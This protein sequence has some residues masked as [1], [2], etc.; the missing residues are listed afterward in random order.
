MKRKP[1]QMSRKLRDTPPKLRVRGGYG[2]WLMDLK[3][4]IR[5][6]Q[7]RAALAVNR[8]LIQLYWDIGRDIVMKQEKERWGA[9]V[10]DRLAA[11]LQRE[12]P[13][14]SG[15]SRSNIFRMR[16]FY[17]ACGQS[18]PIVAQPVRQ[19][20]QNP[21]SIQS[22]IV[23]QPVRQIGQIPTSIQPSIVQQPVG[24]LPQ[25]GP[26][27]PMASLPWGHNITLMETVSDPQARLF[28]ARKAIKNGWSR[29]MLSHWIDSRLHE[30]QGKA[31]TNFKTT[32][33]P[34][35]SDLALQIIKDPYNF[36]FLML[37]EDA[38]EKDLETAL[39]EHI[40]RFLLE[41]TEVCSRLRV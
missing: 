10:I 2:A 41:L 16:A 13:E 38:S 9:S 33:P 18:V 28:Y 40:T 17:V 35:K 11:D 5:S 25:A 15:F 29:N 22:S 37:R 23:A 21:N 19:I 14:M 4:R 32:L 1:R 27:E 30:R 31:V 6:A 8:E 34:E 36:D 3:H 24:Q 20:E 39:L 12:F 26:P 7:I